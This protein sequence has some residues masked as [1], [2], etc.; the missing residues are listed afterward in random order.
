M[1]AKYNHR[2]VAQAFIPNPNNYPAINHK[3]ENK[4]NNYVENLEWCTYKY[5]ANHGTRIERIAQTQSKKVKAINIKTGEVLTFNSVKET[6]SE[7]YGKETVSRACRGVYKSRRT[8]KLIGGDGRT[9][10]GHRWY[11]I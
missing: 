9:Y 5:N 2:I 11:Y 8:G 1:K 4:T 10:R 7:G 3:D 6:G